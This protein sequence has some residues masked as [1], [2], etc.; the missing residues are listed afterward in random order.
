GDFLLIAA[1]QI[2][3]GG[4]QRSGFYLQTLNVI[5]GERTLLVKVD[6]AVGRDLI[7]YCQRCVGRHGH[8]EDYPVM[9]A[10]FRDVGDAEVG[11]VGGTSDARGFAAPDDCTCVGG[12]QAEENAGHF[13][14]PGTN[15]SGQANDFAGA[16]FEVNATNSGVAAAE[17]AQLEQWVANG[18]GLLGKNC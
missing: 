11:R 6:P 17:I 1:R 18:H 8:F 12:G 14:S 2:A 13:G 15:Q 9:A 3:N 5:G 16:D 10:V 7:E 4:L